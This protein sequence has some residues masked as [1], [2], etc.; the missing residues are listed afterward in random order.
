MIVCIV[1]PD[2]ARYLQHDIVLTRAAEKT[3]REGNSLLFLQYYLC[4]GLA[5]GAKLGSNSQAN[6]FSKL[7]S[8][9]LLSIKFHKLER[10]R[11]KRQ[12]VYLGEMIYSGKQLFSNLFSKS[13]E[14]R[15]QIWINILSVARPTHLR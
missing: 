12:S 4:S 15:H 9:G 2:K 5:G 1:F 10:I 7:W 8:E 6:V 11:H 3:S 14:Q 13:T